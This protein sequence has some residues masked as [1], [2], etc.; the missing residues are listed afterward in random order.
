MMDEFYISDFE[1]LQKGYET[2]RSNK[3]MILSEN[4]QTLLLYMLPET[5]IPMKGNCLEEMKFI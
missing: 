2:T 1:K 4:Y 3:K 5:I